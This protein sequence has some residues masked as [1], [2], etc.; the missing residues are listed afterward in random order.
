MIKA[1]SEKQI[2]FLHSLASERVATEAQTTA[3]AR[4]FSQGATSLEASQAI[5]ALLSAPRKVR[6]A[7]AFGGARENV[8]AD[9]PLSKYALPAEDVRDFIPD[10]AVGSN[11][12]VFVEVREFK[13]T[14][15]MRRLSG[16]VGD[17]VRIKISTRAVES[18]AGLIK[19]D[20]PAAAKRFAE[21]YSVCAV[22]SAELTD[23]LSRERGIGPVCWRRFAC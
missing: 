2:A 6:P 12:L 21:H 18:V 4:M 15:Y 8:L 13:G 1:A 10:I 23:K 19:R 14:R 20:A 17:F 9:V 5:T 3:L 16:S 22:C 7:V 11:D